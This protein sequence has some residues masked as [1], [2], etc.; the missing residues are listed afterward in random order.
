MLRNA[1]KSAS[2][3]TLI[4]SAALI[5]LLYPKL[6]NPHALQ[7]VILQLGW[8]GI[9]LDLFVISIQMLFPIIPFALLAG[10]NIILFGWA[11]GFALSLT[12]SLLGSTISFGLARSLG[13]DWAQP[14]LAK[15]GKW[16][17]LSE[18]KNF[19]LIILA[20]LIPILPAAAV[21]YAA[22]ISPMKFTSFFWATLL[23]KLP[24]IAWESWVGHDFWKLFHHP[25]RFTL[26][27]LIGA[28]GIGSAWFGWYFLDQQEKKQ[29]T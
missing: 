12:G 24:M 9:L 28:I 17:K 26:A 19:Y 18:A 4:F 29:E 2:F 20:R 7:T 27:L 3:L 11:L 8:K 23:G 16:A 10:M 21:N 25:W 1:K 13:Q 22:G 14:K 6:Q 15:L 5:L